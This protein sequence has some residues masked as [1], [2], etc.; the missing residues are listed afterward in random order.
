SIAII[1]SILIAALIAGQLVGVAAYLH[2]SGRVCYPSVAED[3]LPQAAILLALRGSDPHLHHCLQRL[4]TQDYPH[5]SLHV[6]LDHVTDPASQSITSWRE[7]HPDFPLEVHYLHDISQH[8]Y[9]KTS[10]MRQCIAGLDAQ[11]GAVLL[12][13]GDTL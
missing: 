7:E 6:I 4:A 5:Y 13:D 3:A 12:V 9:L 10:A 11:I 2:T 1:L 8:A